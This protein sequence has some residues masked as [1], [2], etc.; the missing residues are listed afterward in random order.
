MG[1]FDFL[2]EVWKENGVE[3]IFHK[4]SQ[5]P[6]KPLWFGVDRDAKTEVFGLPGNPISSLICLHKYFLDSQPIRVRLAEDVNF[7][8]NLT[9]FLP[10]SLKQD[11]NAT[12][13][14]CPCKMQNSGQF[15]VLASSD[16]FVELPA[17]KDLFLAGEVYNFYKWRP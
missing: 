17:T 4:V 15:G 11:E 1:K 16:G 6:G 2:P 7:K 12:L 3:K 9:Y 5:K 13:T 10:A 8:K 14:A